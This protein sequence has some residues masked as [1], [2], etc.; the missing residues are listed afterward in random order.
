VASISGGLHKN[1]R[2]P[3][4]QRLLGCPIEKMSLI[5]NKL[6]A[7]SREKNPESSTVAAVAPCEEDRVPMLRRGIRLVMLRNLLS[8]LRELGRMDINSGQFM[9]GVHTTDS[10]TDWREFSRELDEH[11][12]KACCL[13]TGTS[14]VETM[15]DAGLTHDPGSGA[16]Y[17]GDINTFVSYTWRG[18]GASLAALIL[19][20]EDVLTADRIEVSCHKHY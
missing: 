15:V 16:E 8:D 5:L 14:L 11:S 6:A 17:F 4:I 12:G 18:E 20:V 9:N 19:S 1:T 10:A 2:T 3:I 13:H 7:L